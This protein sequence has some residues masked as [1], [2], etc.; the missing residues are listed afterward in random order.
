MGFQLFPDLAHP[1]GQRK[2]PA[3]VP[4]GTA[5][6]FGEIAARFW[7]KSRI[8]ASANIVPCPFAK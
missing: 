4:G 8:T 1:L 7:V 3:G 6:P 5:G 2:F